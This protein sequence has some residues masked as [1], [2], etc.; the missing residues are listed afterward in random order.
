MLDTMNAIVGGING[1]LW[2][3]VLIIV[4]VGIGLYFTLKTGFVQ[5][6]YFFEMFAVL[7][8]GITTHKPKG[9]EISSFQAFCI[10][11]ASRVGVGNI[12]GI[13]IAVVLGGPGAIFWMWVIAIIGSASGF[14]ESTLAQ[15]Y[16]VPYREGGYHGGPAYYIKNALKQP[17]VA[18]LFAILITMTF[19]LFYNSVQSNTIAMALK[20]SFDFN[21]IITGLVL[22][23]LTSM[24]I[25]GGA[26][27]IAKAATFL[28]PIMALLY[29]G[30]AVIIFFKNI[31]LVPNMFYLV[32][33]DAF[34]PQAAVSGGFA[35]V[36]M[37]GIKRG[38]F[39][40]EAG[41]GSVPNAAA[42]AVTSHPVKQGLVQ[43]FGVF[44][45]TLFICTASAVIVLLCQK[46]EVGGEVTGIALMQASLSSE[47]GPFAGYFMSFTITLFAFSSIIGNY[48]YG[49]INM[50][51][52][53]KN[54]YVL[55]VFRIIVVCMVFFGSYA[56]LELVWNLADLFMALL[57]LTNLYAIARLGKFAFIA[58]KDYRTQRQNGIKDPRFDPK[59]L[60]SQ[61][62]IAS[63]GHEKE[64]LSA[65]DE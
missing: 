11:T 51:Y 33:H 28:V 23:I 57:A 9:K 39:S 31:E 3:Y 35:A 40:N 63:W 21:P 32:V 16:K 8:H 49:E 64:Y 20:D 44:V 37:T 12:A 5:I 26:H 53:S 48:Y 52:L 50:G 29:L 1:V 17:A 59:C 47:L 36:V 56:T 55:T 54:P 27:R 34:C 46:Y 41:E 62:G 2:S 13:A 30:V 42:C 10:S 58:L 22:C 14:V 25:F 61:E 43:A 6:R 7:R 60:P 19:A 45:D 38:L 65:H 15:I 4:L 24:I 18:A